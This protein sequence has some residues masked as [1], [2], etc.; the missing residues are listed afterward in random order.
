[1]KTKEIEKTVEDAIKFLEDI[2]LEAGVGI[3]IIDLSLA[4]NHMLSAAAK[5]AM[6][7]KITTLT[8]RRELKADPLGRTF[9][10]DK[11]GYF[12]VMARGDEKI[13]E[14]AKLI[15]DFINDLAGRGFVTGCLAPMSAIA[16]FTEPHRLNEYAVFCYVSLT[17]EGEEYCD[18]METKKIRIKEG[19]VPSACVF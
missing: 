17:P 8:P 2:G 6:A 16:L 11:M 18:N 1:M 13:V 3:K 9:V 5:K 12:S 19:E 15:S 7:V 4:Y 10:D 14:A